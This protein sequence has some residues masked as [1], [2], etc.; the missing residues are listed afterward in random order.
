MLSIVTFVIWYDFG[1]VPSYSFAFLNFI[2]VLIIACP[3]A[4][5]LATPTAI[6]VGT[7]LGAQ[8][9]IL[10]KD[11]QSLEIAGK[12]SAILFDKT[13]TLTAGKPKVT[14]FSFMDQIEEAAKHLEGGRMDSF[15]VKGSVQDY[16]LS[17]IYSLEKHS[18]HALSG[19]IN[20]FIKKKT[21]S[22]KDTSDGDPKGLLRGGVTEMKVED[23][24]AIEG[25]G[26]SG[27]VTLRHPGGSRMDSPGVEEVKVTI[28]NR[29][30]MEKERV[31]RCSELDKKGE[32]WAKEA[33]TLAYVAINGKN[34]ALFAIADTLKPDAKEA[35]RRL[36]EMSIA[37][38]M[39]T[40][41]NQQTARAIAKEAGIDED[42]VFA[43]VLP[44]EKEEKVKHL[45]KNA[46]VL[47][48]GDE[49][50]GKRQACPPKRSFACV[51]VNHEANL[52][53]GGTRKL[54]SNSVVAFIGD[55]INDAPAL[56]AAD[57]GIAMGQGTDIAI[58][59]ASIALL[60]RN[61]TAV[62]AAISLSKKTMRTILENLTW[63]FGY[64]VILIPVAMGVLFPL[65]GVLLNPA[66]ASF[67]M[68]ASSIS[69]VGNSLRLKRLKLKI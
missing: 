48:T 27:K 62:P 37:A 35:V 34:V 3:C 66:L 50:K 26:I 42:K 63:A 59:A 7:G 25:H 19:A 10:I 40:G 12:I 43:E 60:N 16:I 47:E 17:L 53:G 4:L 61:L 49:E 28:G 52:S 38:Y 15:Q 24:R 46:L 41:D 31:I 45:K 21:D 33:K 51:D 58:E 39:V 1:P 23:I 54:I 5:G 29:T 30:L 69:V 55:G 6:M 13:G 65:F 64:N 67:A 44:Q 57:V 9:G 20:E 11:A 68:A 36:K 18:E 2:A 22:L 8:H 32:Q 14:D 56:A